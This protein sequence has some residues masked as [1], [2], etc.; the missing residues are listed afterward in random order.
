M[1]ENTDTPSAPDE[2]LAAAPDAPLTGPDVTDEPAEKPAAA[3]ENAPSAHLVERPRRPR[4]PFVAPWVP[5]ALAIVAAVVILGVG[6]SVLATRAGRV[7]VPNVTGVEVGVATA[8]LA[9]DGLG[10]AVSQRRFSDKPEGQVLAQSPAAGAE[11]KRGD[12][13]SVIVSGG[14]EQFAL[15]DVVGD[16]LLLARGLLEGKG[17]SVHVEIQPSSQPSD[18][19]LASNPSPG[20]MVRT[21]DIITLS[22]AATGTAPGLL[23]PYDF[24]GVTVVIDPA[25]VAGSEQDVPLDVARRLQSLVEASGGTVSSLRTLSETG[26][27]SDAAAR[28]GRATAAGHATVSVGF[29]VVQSGAG[30][31]VAFSPSAGSTAIVIPS[32]ILASSVASELAAVG[33]TVKASTTTT[34]VVLG[35]TQAPWTRVQLGSFTTKEDV[36]SFND[37][38]WA[39]T[40]ARAVYRAIGSLYGKKTSAAQ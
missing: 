8:R 1:D 34:D 10:L 37:P 9:Q 16:G 22:V 11:L 30:G 24:K 27:A 19:V 31:M 23:L 26:T 39:D 28:A 3:T 29:S 38:N 32:K 21:G 13:V 33:E 6:V 12:K 4:P 20:T 40:V 35:A 14:T 18:T 7:A 15:P 5:I 25:P 36:A 17:L 2:G